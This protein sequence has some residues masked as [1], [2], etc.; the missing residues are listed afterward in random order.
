[1]AIKTH[2]LLIALV[3]CAACKPTAVAE[4]DSAESPSVAAVPAPVAAPPPPSVEWV[5]NDFAPLGVT[6]APP[7]VAVRP[8][9]DLSADYDLAGPERSRLAKVRKRAAVEALFDAADVAFPPGQ[10]LLRGYKREAELEVWAAAA[11]GGE[12]R[13]VTTYAVCAASG[14]LG[15]KRR[16]GDRQV[17]EGFY[18]IEYLWPNSD[19]YLSMKVN[20]PNV[21]DRIL[22]DKRMPGSDIMIHGA[23]A[24]IGCLAMSD[25]RIEELWVMGLAANERS[26]IAVHLFPTRDRKVLA[27]HADHA[28]HR[29]FWDNIYQGHDLFEADK[30]LPR[31]RVAPDGRYSFD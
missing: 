6:E 13:H 27:Q 31:V 1:M 5:S 17:P 25:E 4:V 15:P 9:T 19:F 22:G 20:Y 18:T 3:L 11:P 2:P 8:Y 10:L 30:R 12:M 24:S 23:C 29:G 7:R 14:D 26:R 16:E 21:S 28:K